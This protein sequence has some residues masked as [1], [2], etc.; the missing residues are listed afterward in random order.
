MSAQVM[1]EKE[2][3]NHQTHGVIPGCG[4]HNFDGYDSNYL[5]FMINA[6]LTFFK[7]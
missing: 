2:Q 4:E 1:T 7:R 6:H 5:D 3:S